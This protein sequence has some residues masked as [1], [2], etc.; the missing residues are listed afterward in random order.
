MTQEV[1][2]ASS[3]PRGDQSSRRFT[4]LSHAVLFVLGFS[5]IFV[6][7]WGGMATLA[8]QV[9]S[10]YKSELAQ[11]GGVVVILFGSSI[12]ASYGFPGCPMTHDP[13]GMPTAAPGCSPPL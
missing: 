8:G 11:I 2:T 1:T 10:A 5:T 4:T 7:G 3:R 6:V 13:N 9:F 12:W